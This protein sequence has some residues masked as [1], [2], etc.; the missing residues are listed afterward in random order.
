MPLT[1]ASTCIDNADFTVPRHHSIQALSVSNVA[2]IV[3]TH[4]AFG[5]RLR[6]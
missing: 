3:E 4:L 1:L 6:V 2:N 5:P